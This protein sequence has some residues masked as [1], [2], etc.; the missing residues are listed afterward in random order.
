MSI[1]ELHDRLLRRRND[2]KQTPKKIAK[3]LENVAIQA[4]KLYHKYAQRGDDNFRVDVSTAKF[5]GTPSTDEKLWPM[6]WWQITMHL[7][8]TYPTK[9]PS[10]KCF[11][12]VEWSVVEDTNVEIAIGKLSPAYWEDRIEDHLQALLLLAELESKD[13]DY[14]PAK[15]F[16]RKT[17]VP[18][19]RLRMAAMR[20]SL[21]S[22]TK[23]SEKC[24]HV[25]TAIKLWRADMETSEIQAPQKRNKA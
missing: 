7:C 1:Q 20:G 22:V 4:A 5:T 8:V 18:A 23:R 12:Q 2:P 6:V 10:F 19:G 13:H 11:G 25:P 9:M 14:Q 21:P 16:R 17:K 24:Y 15:W 3:A